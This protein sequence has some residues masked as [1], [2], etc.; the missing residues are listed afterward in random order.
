ML[1]PEAAQAKV[2]VVASAAV[3]WLLFGASALII[4]ADEL[5]RLGLDGAPAAIVSWCIRVAAWLGTAS[6]IISR[7][8]VLPPEQRGILSYPCSHETEDDGLR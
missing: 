3:T 6:A 5:T 8:S 2:R 4:V 7:V 1:S